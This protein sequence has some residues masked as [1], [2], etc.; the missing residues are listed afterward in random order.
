[1]AHSQ[2]ALI[3]PCCAI[4]K[5]YL[6]YPSLFFT[7]GHCRFYYLLLTTPHGNDT[8]RPHFFICR[9]TLR[10]DLKKCSLQQVQMLLKHCNLLDVCIF[11]N[12]CT[13]DIYVSI[14]KFFNLWLHDMWSNL[15]FI[16]LC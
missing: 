11:N 13:N 15:S 12:T 9:I 6:V 8:V 3:C 4:T 5:I 16:W 2:L 14:I 1:M 10:A 7:K